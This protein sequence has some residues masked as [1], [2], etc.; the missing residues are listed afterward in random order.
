M[1]NN[2]S[3][4]GVI[5]VIVAVLVL[6]AL[7]FAGWTVLKKSNHKNEVATTASSKASIDNDKKVEDKTPVVEA[8]NYLVVKEWGVKYELDQAITNATYA[9]KQPGYQYVTITTPRLT[10]LAQSTPPCSGAATSISLNRAKAGDDRF[11]SPWT[12]EQL[13]QIGTKSGDY[14]YFSEGGRA[15]FGSEE[16]L[17]QYSQAVE[18][19]SSIRGK[20]GS[21][22]KTVRPE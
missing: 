21:I 2:Q 9:M 19:I 10:E 1:K 6:G 14:Y 13:Q 3:G 11:G 22:S 18:E 12:D 7:S 5:A 4:F 20:L 8:K 16:D 17:K 15:C